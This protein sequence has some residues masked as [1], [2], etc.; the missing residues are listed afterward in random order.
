MPAGLGLVGT[1]GMAHAPDARVHLSATVARHALPSLCVADW[2][3]EIGWAL[4][5]SMRSS[6]SL[7][8]L[9]PATPAP[10][11]A[12]L[13]ARLV[14][15]DGSEWLGTA[16]GAQGRELG[17]VVFNTSLSGYQEILTDPSY[18]GQFVVFTCPHIGNVGI[19]RED[20]ESERCHL[21]AVIVR[22]LSATVS[23]YRS[24]QTLDAY[25]RAQGVLGIAGVDTRAITRRLRVRGCL[26]GVV[27]TDVTTPARELVEQARSWSILGKDLI[28]EVS[29]TE[30]Y[31]WADPTLEEWEFAPTVLD[32]DGAPRYHVVAYDFGIKHNIL[33]RLA[34]FGCRITV[35]PAD[36]PAEKVLELNPDGV[37]F[38]NGPGDPSAVPYAVQNARDL[39]GVKPVF[40]ICMGHQ[41]SRRGKGGEEERGGLPRPCGRGQTVCVWQEWERRGHRGVWPAS[42]APRARRMAP[43]T[44]ARAPTPQVLGQ[45]FGGTTF[46][47]PFGHHGGNHPIRFTPT[48]RIEISAQNHNFAV[49]P[50]T[51]PPDVVVSHVN[52]ND[53]TCAGM[54]Y[55]AKK[56]M[57]IQYHPEASPGPH[58][59]DICFEQF[60]D[61]M[62]AEHA[63]IHA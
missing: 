55:P 60:V 40:G 34:A 39:L 57:T 48:G 10:L 43:T 3:W 36:Y 37:F 26:N 53:G 21:G 50:A 54:L 2:W 12:P 22:D 29:C 7:G 47:L 8:P 45:A 24:T 4:A 30:P 6:R 35:V 27:T 56:A 52:L 25:L 63:A 49:D 51:L 58:D 61:M 1:A 17:E 20:W 59:A 46:K 9:H 44:A 32:S 28:R 23:N 41:V 31:E 5:C 15:E 18:K 11:A 42:H 16:F 33:R 13:P 19:N 62:K 14:L 38:S